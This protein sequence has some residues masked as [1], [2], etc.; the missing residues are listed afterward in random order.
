MGF[1]DLYT[2]LQSSLMLTP[3][4]NESKHLTTALTPGTLPYTDR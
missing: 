1:A 4:Q 3:E 2:N